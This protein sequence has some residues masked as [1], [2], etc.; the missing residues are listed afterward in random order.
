MLSNKENEILIS[1]F[2]LKC[3]YSIGNKILKKQN[4]FKEI[5]SLLETEANFKQELTEK[6]MVLYN[7]K[8]KND[9][10]K[11]EAKVKICFP[12]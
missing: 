11:V 8:S 2:I 5:N 7:L 12:I 3:Y 6:K 1:D 9:N 10:L 4:K